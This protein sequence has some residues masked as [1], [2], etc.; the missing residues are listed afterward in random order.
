MPET[1]EQLARQKIDAQLDACGR[2]VRD[3]STINLSVGRGVAIDELSFATGEPDY[4]LFVEVVSV[5]L[6]HHLRQA[7]LE[8]FATIAEDLKE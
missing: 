3:K 7:A 4:S 8:E 1:P 6:Q 5:N 2:T